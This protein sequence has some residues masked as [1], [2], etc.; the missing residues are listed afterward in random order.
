M[1]WFITD[2]ESSYYYKE[3]K[4]SKQVAAKTSKLP[5]N[6]FCYVT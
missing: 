2:E 4:R 1:L 6:T 5:E 3:H